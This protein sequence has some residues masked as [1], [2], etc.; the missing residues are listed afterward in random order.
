MAGCSLYEQREEALKKLL[1][2]VRLLLGHVK[3][4]AWCWIYHTA[5]MAVRE[6]ERE[7]EGEDLYGGEWTAFG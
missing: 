5:S 7:E 3:E 6:R 2:E 1:K 4:W